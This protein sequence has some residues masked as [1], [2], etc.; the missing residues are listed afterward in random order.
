MGENKSGSV[1]LRII[2]FNCSSVHKIH[3][4]SGT[5]CTHLT[6]DSPLLSMPVWN[7]SIVSASCDLLPLSSTSLHLAFVTCRTLWASWSLIDITHFLIYLLHSC[8]KIHFSAKNLHPFHNTRLC[9]LVWTEWMRITIRQFDNRGLFT[10]TIVL[11]E[12]FNCVSLQS[13]ERSKWIPVKTL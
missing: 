3:I 11:N 5:A 9:S 12:N 10:T 8:N 2:S 4:S 13:M 6:K 7:I 1:Q